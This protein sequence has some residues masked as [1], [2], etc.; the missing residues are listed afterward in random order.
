MD[1]SSVS[2]SMGLQLDG[3]GIDMDKPLAASQA[4]GMGPLPAIV[5]QR[6]Q[7]VRDCRDTRQDARG[8]AS[9]RFENHVVQA[10]DESNGRELCE[11]LP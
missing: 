6:D 2:E 9:L 1:G 8:W 4:G 10:R 5:P 11:A 3:P 7:A